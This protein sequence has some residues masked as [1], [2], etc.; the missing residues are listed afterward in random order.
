[1]VIYNLSQCAYST[2]QLQFCRKKDGYLFTKGQNIGVQTALYVLNVSFNLSHWIFACSYWLL[3][4]RLKLYQQQKSITQYSFHQQAINLVVTFLIFCLPLIGAVIDVCGYK[5]AARNV[6]YCSDSLLVICCGFLVDGL[7]RMVNGMTGD[8][9]VN[10][11]YLVAHLLVY[12]LVIVTSILS[13]INYPKKHTTFVMIE[14]FLI[15]G[16]IS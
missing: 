11:K 14:L 8:H 7:V 2:M 12:L 16:L 5:Q 10:V 15:A 1:M 4:W 3:S 6:Y 13:D 9:L